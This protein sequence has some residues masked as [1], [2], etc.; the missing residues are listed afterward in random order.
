MA[1]GCRCAEKQDYSVYLNLI[2]DT[3]YRDEFN[4]FV[5]L[6]NDEIKFMENR[7]KIYIPTLRILHR[8]PFMMPHMQCDK[9]AIKHILSGSNVMCPGLTSP[10]GRMDN[11]KEG[12]VVAIMAEGKDHAMGIGVTAMSTEDI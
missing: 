3:Q 2:S 9:G 11:V 6:I 4:V 8:Y 12:T 10:G 1:K 5:Y 7:S